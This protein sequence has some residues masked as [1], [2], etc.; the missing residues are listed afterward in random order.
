MDARSNLLVTEG[1]PKL[2]R[3]DDWLNARVADY[4]RVNPGGEFPVNDQELVDCVREKIGRYAKY[5][6]QSPYGRLHDEL[7]QQS[8][9][10]LLPSFKTFEQKNNCKFTSWLFKV[11]LTT[12][13]DLIRRELRDPTAAAPDEPHDRAEQERSSQLDLSV[14]I[15]E[16]IDAAKL[17][18]SLLACLNEREANV[19]RLSLK[20]MGNAQISQVLGMPIGTVSSILC[21]ARGLFR[22]KLGATRAGGGIRKKSKHAS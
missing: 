12:K 4:V 14:E 17:R 2:G 22:K 11:V 21:R 20:E 6:L 13:S 5:F 9:V 15:I 3:D 18:D 7:E 8:W 10:K 19:M 16:S 1:T